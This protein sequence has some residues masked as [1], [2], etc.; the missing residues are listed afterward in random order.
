[1]SFRLKRQN[2]TTIGELSLEVI[3][4]VDYINS[5]LVTTNAVP[6]SAA[7]QN[8]TITLSWDGTTMKLHGRAGQG[9]T[10]VTKGVTLT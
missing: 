10:A 7:G 9:Q 4:L 6:N 3:A 8:G 5:M 2:H 1:M